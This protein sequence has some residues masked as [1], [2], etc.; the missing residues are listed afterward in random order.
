MLTEAQI[1]A[2]LHAYYCRSYPHLGRALEHDTDLLNDWFV[3]SFG[4]IQTVQF[5]EDTFGVAV[6]RA[7]IHADNFHSVR[8]LAAFVR[9]K[10]GARA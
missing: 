1:A 9:R 10:L 4:V 3:D 5:L 8:S 2:Q 7:D 6:D